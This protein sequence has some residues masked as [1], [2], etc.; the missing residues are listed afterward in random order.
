M[1]GDRIITLF[2]P[3]VDLALG[4]AYPLAFVMLSIASVLMMC[5]QSARALQIGRG[6]ALGYLVLQLLP[7]LLALVRELGRA[8]VLVR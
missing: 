2:G 4:L 8:L 7:A 3:V 1:F 6:A 5:G